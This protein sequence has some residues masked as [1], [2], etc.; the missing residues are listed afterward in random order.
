MQSKK[1]K[2]IIFFLTI[3][4][5]TIIIMVVDG[6]A[7]RLWHTVVV[8]CLGVL[9]IEVDDQRIFLVRIE[10][11]RIDDP[12]EHLL[13]VGSFHP[14]GFYTSHLQLIIEM[15][16]LKGQLRHFAVCLNGVDLI[17]RTH[18]VTLHD[19]PVATHSQGA[20]ISHL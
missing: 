13:A 3:V 16:V 1:L 10:V 7:V 2:I 19:H 8:Q 17:R 9:L 15:L 6:R 18:G 5:C 20:V 14:F 12:R 11:R 4:L